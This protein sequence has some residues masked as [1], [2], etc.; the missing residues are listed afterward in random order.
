MKRKNPV[1]TKPPAKPLKRMPDDSVTNTNNGMLY[2]P[3]LKEKENQPRLLIN[4]LES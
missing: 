4:S 3:A 1:H 2:A